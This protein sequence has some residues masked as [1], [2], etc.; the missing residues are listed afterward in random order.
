MERQVHPL[1][2]KRKWQLLFVLVI[3]LFVLFA[4]LQNFELGEAV[5]RI[6]K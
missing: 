3:S 6:Q 1:L 2:G 4:C 5:T